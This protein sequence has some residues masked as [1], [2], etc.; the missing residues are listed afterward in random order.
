MANL[1]EAASAIK[2]GA[3]I[4][5]PKDLADMFEKEKLTMT[6]VVFG[7]GVGPAPGYQMLSEALI[8]R[9]ASNP[10]AM[11]A[12]LRENVVVVIPK[13]QIRL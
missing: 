8:M 2:P 1:P 7:G 5:V 3:V 13:E 4:K 9:L 11:K 10:A 6:N 12:I